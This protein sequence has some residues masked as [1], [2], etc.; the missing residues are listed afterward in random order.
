MMRPAP[1]RSPLRGRS[2]DVRMFALG[3]GLLR[4]HIRATPSPWGHGSYES[5][6]S[7]P[8]GQGS[9]AFTYLLRRR[10]DTAPTEMRGP[11]P[12]GA[13]SVGEASMCGCSP[14]GQ[15][16]Y[17]DHVPATPSPWGHGSYEST[18]S[19]PWGQGSYAFTYLLRRGDT[20]PTEM[21]G[22]P[23]RR[24]P[25]RGRSSD[26]RMFARMAGLLRNHTRATPSP[27]GHGSYGGKSRDGDRIC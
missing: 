19:S 20:A 23:P 13:H 7:S 3:T 2:I 10:G 17:V 6:P 26:V 22:P 14:W 5:T 11:H 24:S 16:S 18:P 4:N 21:R 27:W 1:C 12:V 15:G 25:L 9:Y 8:W